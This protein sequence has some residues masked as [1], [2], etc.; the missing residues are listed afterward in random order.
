VADIPISLPPTL[1]AELSLALETEGKIP[2]ALDA[3]GPIGDRDVVLVGGG[4]E[5]MRRLSTIGARI[6]NVEPL[7][8]SETAAWPLPTDSADA[9]VAEWS[10]FRGVS[11]KELD[12][13]QRILRPGGRLLVV[14]DYGRDDV[15]RLRG[16]QPEYSDWSRRDGPF[17]SAG[18][19]IRVVH[20]FWTFGSVA[21]AQAF[22]AAAFGR[23]GQLVADE[24]KR[25]RLS[26]NV[27]IYHRDRAERA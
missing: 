10:A 14:H 19:R 1:A 8:G 21:A 24:L 2:R 6:T 11:G 3:L 7:N 25:P 20:C 5:E 17:L 16:D 13:A 26:Y 9:V 22:L 4:T 23:A 15:S 12:E 27:A 18:F